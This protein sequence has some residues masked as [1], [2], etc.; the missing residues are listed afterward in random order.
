MGKIEKWFMNRAHH[1]KRA[2]M[3]AEKFLS[4]INPNPEQTYLEIGCGNGAAAK[5]VAKKY[6]INVTGIDIDPEQIQHANENIDNI[7]NIRFSTVD[8]TKL[9]F[10]D[11]NFDI[12]STFGV[13]HHVSDW[14][15]ALGEMNRVLKPGG[16]LIYFDFMYS[17]WL[18][19]IGKSFSK[20]YGFVTIYELNSFTKKNNLSVIHSSFSKSLIFNN[21]EA[22]YKK[23]K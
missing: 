17:K 7:P 11:N 13:M 3:R 16:Y 5:H 15:G 22:V 2:Q 21:Y 10:E 19:K 14:L 1:E 18:A 12:V 6:H 23:E 8:G 4:F 9:P 20:N